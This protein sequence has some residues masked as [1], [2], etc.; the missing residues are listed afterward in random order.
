MVTLL[1]EGDD[2]DA[3][4]KRV[5]NELKPLMIDGLGWAKILP[6]DKLSDGRTALSAVKRHAE[7]KSL[8]NI[9][10]VVAYIII[11][12]CK[13]EDP[14]RN[15]SLWDYIQKHSPAHAE[16]AD[17]REQIFESKKVDDFLKDFTDPRLK[18]VNKM[19]PGI[20]PRTE[21]LPTAT[22]I[23]RLSNLRCSSRTRQI[24]T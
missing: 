11:D 24:V 12:T 15:F 7:G 1:L 17:L 2:Y 6:F 3:D 13:Y 20:I 19:S 5:Y 10:M 8:K 22:S 23:S 9:R 4:S 18:I 14:I 21:M 16:L